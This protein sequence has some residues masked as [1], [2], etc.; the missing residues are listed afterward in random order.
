MPTMAPARK[1]IQIA[2]PLLVAAAA[3]AGSGLIHL[4][5]AP[6]HFKEWWG[7]GTFF[8]LCAEAQLAWALLV[9]SRPARKLLVFGAAASLALVALW[10]V[11]RTSGLPFGPEPGTAEEV[12]TPD[13]ISVALELLTAA[14]CAWALAAPPAPGRLPAFA[15]RLAGF[16]AVTSLTA[17]AIAAV[18]AT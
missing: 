1:D 17:W 5:V 14:G 7:F 16:A 8:V 3:A 4:A 2:S 9:P 12:G 10:A 18:A 6:E 11:S 13:L 15:P